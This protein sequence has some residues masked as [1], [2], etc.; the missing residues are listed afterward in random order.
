MGGA[1][2]FGIALSLV[3]LGGR[4]TYV[5]VC[6]GDGLR[7]IAD[8]Q[9]LGRSALP[10]RRGFIYDTSGRIAAATQWRPSVFA[11]PV[12]IDDI[13][14][15]ASQLASVLGMHAGE[16]E[17]ELRERSTKR[18]CWLRRL[19][20][21]AD[22]EAVEA[23][24]LPGIGL[25]HE[26]Q[27]V[28]PMGA[29]MGATVGIVGREDHGLEGVELAFDAHLRGEAG[30]ITSIHDGRR[31]R[32]P[33]WMRRDQSAAPRDGGHV[34]L[35]L[36]GVVQEILLD[37]LKGAVRSF[38]A[39]SAVGVVMLPETGAVLAMGQW[40]AF[41]PNDYQKA[42]AER[43]RNRAVTDAREPGSVFKGYVACGALQM[44][45]VRS[46]EQIHC[47]NGLHYFGGR[48]M[49]DTTPLGTV[50]FERILAKSSNIGM[51]IIGERMGNAALH[52]T[53]QAFG[54]GERT[55]IGFPGEAAGVVRPLEQ[56]TR[57]STTSIPIGQEVA[58]TPLQLAAAF[59]AIVN[60]GVLKRP[61][62]VRAMLNARGE[63]EESFESGGD[64]RRVMPRETADYMRD[65]VLTGV[66]REGGGV[67]AATKDWTVAGKT[68]TA[69]LAYRGRRGYEPGAYQSSFIG[70][71]PAEAPEIV[72][73]VQ[74]LRPNAKI[75]YYGGLVAAPAAKGIFEKTLSYLGVPPSPPGRRVGGT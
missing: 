33:I 41:D 48:P 51:G 67:K 35:T 9:Q 30:W 64:V 21:P 14:G 4:V 20:D 13:E 5:H 71:A 22:G 38:K 31:A 50:T 10:A 2:L 73:V 17:Q 27:R 16:I 43:R 62:Y 12:L 32:R 1:I 26:P 58:A 34:V 47:H 24:K 61:F 68:G 8:R 36:D 60:G 75:G 65:V 45:A 57:Y 6:L 70:A 7:R 19:I 23:L 25:R 42:P 44:K 37:E 72:V 18:F 29:A 11:D 52:S 56:W 15:T 28:Y 46:G 3:V 69:Q 59:C 53:L 40:P 54:F 55:G 63:I 66:V 74:V 49:H 39:E